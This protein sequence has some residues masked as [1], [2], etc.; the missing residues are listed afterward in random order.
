MKAPLFLVFLL[1]CLLTACFRP[2]ENPKEVA[3]NQEE[4]WE[5]I[6]QQLVALNDEHFA[7]EELD[8]MER[9]MF[10]GGVYLD[11][12]LRPR[13]NA[14]TIQDYAV[15]ILIDPLFSLYQVYFFD[16]HN[17]KRFAAANDPF[18]RHYIKIKEVDVLCQEE[19]SAILISRS[20][21]TYG[22]AHELYRYN[23]STQGVEMIFN[24]SFS[25]DA[26]VDGSAHTHSNLLDPDQGCIDTI[27]T[28]YLPRQID[29]TGLELVQNLPKQTYVFDPKRQAFIK[30]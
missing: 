28:Y 24:Q 8:S 26:E 22:H 17:G 1:S 3:L 29:N 2:S 23:D 25:F 9:E 4:V 7:G 27:Y 10:L 12:V 15:V 20:I 6:H 18:A 14:D 21:S 16:G 5:L 19:K 30:L 13:L 11:T